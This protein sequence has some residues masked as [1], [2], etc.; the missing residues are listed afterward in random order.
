MVARDAGA[1]LARLT[2]DCCLPAPFAHCP[3][4]GGRPAPDGGA[5]ARAALLLLPLLLGACAEGGL[6]GG[7][8]AAGVSQTPDEFMV[9]PTRPLEMPENLAALPPPTPGV[10]NRV[11]YQPHREAIAGLTGAPGPAGNADAQV[12]VAAAGPIA[13]GIRQTL[14]AEDV[15]WRATHNGLLL[16]RL[17][18]KDRDELEYRPMVLDAAA[19][20]ERMR[21]AGVDVPAAPPAV[22]D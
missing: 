1:C 3:P 22:L 2:E 8:R 16:E 17:L 7:L 15:E 12:L 14:A 21:A 20:F 6:A 10:A 11:D 4:G 13:P 18:S 5:L 9:L 19:E